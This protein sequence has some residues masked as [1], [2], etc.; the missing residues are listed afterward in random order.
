MKKVFF[1]NFLLMTAIISFAQ[2]K[3]FDI[4]SYTPPTDWTEKQ[5]EGN[6]SYSRIDGGS[7]AQ[8]AI[9]TH[10]SCVGDIQADFD[11]DWNELV[12]SG[13]TIS[14]P[15]RNEP[16]SDG[17]W[18]VM[19][20]SGVW[21]YNGSNVAS[22]LT[23]YSNN[24]VCVAVLCNSTAMPYLKEYQALIGTIDIDA[25]AAANTEE[26]QEGTVTSGQDATAAS[27]VGLWVINTRESSGFVNGYRMYTGGYMRKEYQVNADGSYVFREKNWLAANDAIYFVYESGTWNA[28]GSEVTFT[29]GKGKAGWWNKDKVTNDV[30]KWGAFKKAAQYKLQSVTYSY[31]IKVDTNYGNSIVLNTANSTERDG[32][33]FNK[34]PF[35]FVYTSAKDA[36]IDNPPGF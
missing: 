28:N 27:V 30:N 11:K 15:E 35:R 19:S 3:T 22:I 16:K 8:I 14:T 32:G 17:G 21:Q 23:V 36:Y 2:Q 34:G 18:S 4:T 10:R 1:I 26:P 24:T 25:S 13:K 9:Y 33:Q 12:A 20:G 29:P 5:G 7:W 31:E 6:I